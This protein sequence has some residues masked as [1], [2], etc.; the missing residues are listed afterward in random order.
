VRV[1]ARRLVG[2]NGAYVE[3][4]AADEAGAQ[5]LLTP[6][7][8]VDELANWRDV[9]S[10]RAMWAAAFS[11][12]PKMPGCRLAVLTFAGDPGH[13]SWKVRERA[14]T[15]KA[16]R[17]VELP[18][19]TPWMRP[20]DLDEQRALLLPS[21]YV[22]RHENKWV[23]GEDKLTTVEDV[24]ACIGHVGDLEPQ[25]G[26]RHVVTLDVGLTNDR[27]ACVVAHAERRADGLVV[28]VDRLEVWQGRR[29]RPVSLDVVEAWVEAACRDYRASLVFDPYQAQHL[30]QR[31][32][33]KSVRV[34]EHTFTQAST[35]RL[36]VTLF[37]LL[38]GHLLDL[39][40]DDALV[41]ELVN[42]QLREVSPG[43]YRIDHQSGRHDDRAIAVAM[44]AAH[45]VE[46]PGSTG[47]VTGWADEPR[48]LRS[49]DR[50]PLTGWYDPLTGLDLA[51]G[52]S[53]YDRAR[54][55]KPDG[56]RW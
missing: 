42:V 7:V 22:R 43:S 25:R 20:E 41:D 40:D 51:S 30:A 54:F 32:R 35:G 18:G 29:D 26:C 23:S 6:W 27:T 31:L 9:E 8:V 14:R 56:G 34:V 44:A 36:A 55:R 24:R 5:D 46:R 47:P 16:W 21:Q 53:E 52:E 49:A 39:P 38:R 19:P 3:A 1:E 11:A 37:R 50:D 12:V 28:V 4:L 48:T 2:P 10:A 45:L 13:F 17:F 33:A 15:S